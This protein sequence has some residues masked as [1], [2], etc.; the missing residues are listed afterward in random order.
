MTDRKADHPIDPL[1]LE[2]WS[3]RAFDGSEIP[4]AD[5]M[6]I[7]EETS[8]LAFVPQEKMMVL[9]EVLALLHRLKMPCA[10]NIAQLLLMLM[11]MMQMTKKHHTQQHW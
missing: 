2:R 8:Q 1:F 10:R 11:W 6:T 3:P 7:F 9:R 5:L 4:D